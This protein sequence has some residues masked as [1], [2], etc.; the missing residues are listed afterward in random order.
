MLIFAN[1]SFGLMG[2]GVTTSWD[3]NL[4]ADPYFIVP[5]SSGEMQ[6]N[7]QPGSKIPTSVF[8]TGTSVSGSISGHTLT[9]TFAVA[10]AAGPFSQGIVVQYAP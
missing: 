7:F 8:N 6:S 3:I 10:P 4:Q 5:Y 1:L 9:I 2:D